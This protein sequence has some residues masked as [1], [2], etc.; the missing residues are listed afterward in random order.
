MDKRMNGERISIWNAK[1]RFKENSINIYL[2]IK[3]PSFAKIK[4]K[5]PDGV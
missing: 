5:N 2:K 3:R 4:G 1:K